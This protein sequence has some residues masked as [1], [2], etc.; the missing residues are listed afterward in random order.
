[1]FLSKVKQIFPTV[2]K[3]EVLII[4]VNC[5]SYLERGEAEI[6]Y[7]EIFGV[8][9]GFMLFSGFIIFPSVLLFGYIV[10]YF[11]R[12]KEKAS[13]YYLLSGF[14]SVAISLASYLIVH[15]LKDLV[16]L[17][18]PLF[19]VFSIPCAVISTAFFLKLHYGSFFRIPTQPTAVRDHDHKPLNKTSGTL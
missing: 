9:A 13:A 2:W 6:N 12:D 15:F 18:I 3:E 4:Y 19:P 11:S 1:M 8:L 5:A 7:M 14:L 16:P 17:W 10:Y